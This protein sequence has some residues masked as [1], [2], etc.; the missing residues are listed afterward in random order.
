[1]E[2]G[3]L[4]KFEHFAVRFNN[5]SGPI[6]SKLFNISALK[7]LYLSCNSL[8]GILPLEMGYSLPNLEQLHLT[9]NKLAGKIPN[10]LFNASLLTKIDLSEN[11]FSGIISTTFRYLTILEVLH[12]GGNN[13]TIADSDELYFL[14][15]F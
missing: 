15:K 10:G 1:M 12:I 9:R 14:D 6:P 2:I 5:L 7:Y 4:D 11:G 3:D 13:L 8:S